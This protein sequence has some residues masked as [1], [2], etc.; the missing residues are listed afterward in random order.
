MLRCPYCHTY[1]YEGKD[2]SPCPNCGRPLGRTHREQAAVSVTQEKPRFE[3]INRRTQ[4]LLTL[5]VISMILAVV[6]IFSDLAQADLVSRVIR[7]EHV[8]ELEAMINDSRQA[9]IGFGQAVLAIAVL[10]ALLVWVYRANKNLRSLR[11]AGLVFT[12]GWA[13]GWFFVPFMS[14]FR[15]YQV[16]SEIWRA[17]HPEVDENDGT[18]WKAVGASPVVGCWWAVFLIS[19]VLG[20]GTAQMGLSAA[21]PREL[22]DL[23]YAL[24]VSDGMVVVYSLITILMVRRISQFQEAK[25]RLISST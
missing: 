6:A 11:A 14:L 13:V 15:P 21:T 24:V 5:L 3:P 8:T 2:A 16:V 12:P 1:A 17:S 9:A 10:V 7:G 20:F 23:T 19:G 18:A 25:N 4:V 22:L